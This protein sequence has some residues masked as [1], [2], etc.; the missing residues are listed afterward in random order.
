MPVIIPVIFS[1]SEVGRQP[2][3]IQRVLTERPGMP[4]LPGRVKRAGEIVL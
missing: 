4:H 2:T 3:P 1:C